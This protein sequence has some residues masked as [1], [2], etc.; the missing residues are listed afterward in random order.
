ML[1]NEKGELKIN[2]LPQRIKQKLVA[3]KLNQD[4]FGL[5]HFCFK[6]SAMIIDNNF[7]IGKLSGFSERVQIRISEFYTID[8]ALKPLNDWKSIGKLNDGVIEIDI[9]EDHILTLLNVGMG[10]SGFQKGGPFNVYGAIYENSYRREEALKI[11]EK[12]DFIDSNTRIKSIIMKANHENEY[13]LSGVTRAFN[14]EPTE[15]L[16]RTVG[17]FFT[18][19]RCGSN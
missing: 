9:D 14:S 2:I 6:N 1:K 4:S 16:L 5:N 17:D 19:E 13:I 7:Y 11:A 18:E 8:L 12:Y 15:H 10:P 3:I